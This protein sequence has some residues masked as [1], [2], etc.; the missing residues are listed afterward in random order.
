MAHKDF[1]FLHER[2]KASLDSLI[3]DKWDADFKVFL[4]KMEKH[5]EMPKESYFVYVEQYLDGEIHF[6]KVECNEDVTVME[7]KNLYYNE[8]IKK[9][10]AKAKEIF[11]KRLEHESPQKLEEVKKQEEKIKEDLGDKWIDVLQIVL[12]EEFQ[13]CSYEWGFLTL[14]DY[15]AAEKLRE[16]RAKK[17]KFIPK[18]VAVTNLR[19]AGI[20][21]KDHHTLKNY[22]VPNGA[23]LVHTRYFPD[24]DKME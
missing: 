18:R 15:E 2:A 21:M 20:Y 4:K 22:N 10:K 12:P 6:T 24:L 5:K 1:P 3:L 14:E 7:L 17:G 9:R 11:Y 23:H 8:R 16:E 13:Q 19:Y